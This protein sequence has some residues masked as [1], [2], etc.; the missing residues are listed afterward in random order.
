VIASQRIEGID[1]RTHF[2]VP[3]SRSCSD[4]TNTP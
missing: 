3:G 4:T 1:A 2:A